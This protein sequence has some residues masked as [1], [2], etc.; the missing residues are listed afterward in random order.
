M[1][2]IQEKGYRIP[3]DIAVIG[4]DDIEYAKYT[5][6]PLTTI[7]QDADRIGRLAMDVLINKINNPEAPQQQ[8]Y[9]PPQFIQR[10][11]V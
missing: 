6:P 2:A 10:S 4:Y 1:S 5:T 11:S 8:I 9:L 7:R 3:E